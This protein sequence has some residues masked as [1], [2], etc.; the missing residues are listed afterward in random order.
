MAE[1][2]LIEVLTF[3]NQWEATRMKA[4]LE[5]HE[6]PFI[7]KEYQD[8]EYGNIKGKRGWGRL[9]SYKA[10]EQEILNFYNE[11]TESN[12]LDDEMNNAE[13]AISESGSSLS[14]AINQNKKWNIKNTLI[15]LLLVSTSYLGFKVYAF[16]RIINRSANDKNFTHVY[17]TS[18][19]LMQWKCSGK[20][21]YLAE[22]G[23]G[24]GTFS[25]FSISDPNGRVANV[26]FDEDQDGVYEKTIYLKTNNDTIE[27]CYDKN[28]DAVAD[29]NVIYL[30]ENNNLTFKDVNFDREWDSVLVNNK[31]YSMNE[32]TNMLK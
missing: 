28:N 2:K 14:N 8:L 12:F 15:F 4:I 21:F 26:S 20:D 11:K 31:R 18:F 29:E 1:Q 19:Y 7:I 16:N 30:S 5:E 27:I 17:G 32:F 10:F 25:K 9:E 24:N 6:I 13:N 23:Y 22:D 3:G